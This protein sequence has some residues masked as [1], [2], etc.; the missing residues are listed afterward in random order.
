MGS[1]DW[2]PPTNVLVFENEV[3]LPAWGAWIEIKLQ[4][5][6]S[7]YLTCRSPHGERG[8]KCPSSTLSAN[9]EL[10][11]PAWGAWIEMPMPCVLFVC[12][13]VAPRM[14]SVDWNH[15]FPGGGTPAQVA[16]PMGSVDWNYKA[17][18]EA[19]GYDCRSPHGERGLKCYW[20]FC[21][22]GRRPSLPAWGAWIEISLVQVLEAARKVAPRMGSVD[23]NK[24]LIS[25][26]N[27]EEVAPRMGSVDWNTYIFRVVVVPD[28][29]SPHG[30]RGLKLLPSDFSADV[31]LSLPA[32]GAWI[33]I[34]SAMIL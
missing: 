8:L 14:G 1:V 21:K 20:H 6:R 24:E 25:A 26:P 13:P 4:M 17:T 34:S 9:Y 2:N 30:E 10:S 7:L 27:E 3:S 16:P 18:M 23:W 31:W 29:R 5:S 11:L 33:E 32:W 28:S 22:L 12:P 19:L 15:C